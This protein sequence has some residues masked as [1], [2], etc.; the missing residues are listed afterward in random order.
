MIA[1]KQHEIEHRAK[2][3]I[4]DELVK[5]H[6][7]AVPESLVDR[8]I[9]VRL[10]R[11]LRALAAQGMRTEDMRKMDFPRLRS[12]Q[13]DAATREVKSS[14]ILDKIAE[15]EKIE[16]SDAELDREIEQIASQAR[17]P[18]EAIRARLEKEGG[19][20]RVRARMRNEK[21]LDF[22]YRKSA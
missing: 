12:G 15:Q 18:I 13:R 14:L 9:D 17:Q 8:Q 16:V 20:D 2:E 21:T 1:E 11:G 4:L 3:Q 5:Q 22:L 6:E 7:F 19:L 10:E